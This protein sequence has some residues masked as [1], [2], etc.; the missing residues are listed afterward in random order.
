[1]RK[2]LFINSYE[3]KTFILI[4]IIILLSMTDAF[5][6]LYL[7]SQGLSELNL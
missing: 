6:T 7:I 4:L 3:T 1:M 5:I 2:T